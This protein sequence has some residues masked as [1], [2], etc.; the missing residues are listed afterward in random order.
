MVMLAVAVVFGAIA[1][2]LVNNLLTVKVAERA[3]IGGVETRPL[4][5]AAVD[6]DVGTRVDKAMLRTV[7]WPAASVP[8]GAYAQA[9]AV[10]GTE[11]PVVLREIR[12]GEPV[13]AYKLSPHGARGGLTVRIPE[14]M[15]AVTIAVNEVRGVAGFVLPGDRVDVLSTS[16]QGRADNAPVTRVIAQNV[17]V[18]GVDQSSSEK[19][20]DPQVVNAVTLLVTP[21]QGQKIAL[22]QRIGDVTLLLRNE[23]DVAL[24]RTGEVTLAN[25]A[26]PAAAPVATQPVTAAAGRA[27]TGPPQTTVRLIRGLKVDQ[28]SVNKDAPPR[29]AGASQVQSGGGK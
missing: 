4:V 9:D 1:V 14:N 26:Q 17:P 29:Q 11:P 12:K 18:L 2:F 22:A 24:P 3:E 20:T 27:P 16:S 10:I 5:V 23:A 25:L 21:E 13:L 6:L 19:K 15:R 28:V 7:A 8:Q